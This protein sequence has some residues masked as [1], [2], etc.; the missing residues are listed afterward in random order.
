MPRIA[1][2]GAN[3]LPEDAHS[4]LEFA[5]ANDYQAVELYGGFPQAHFEDLDGAAREKL[6]SLA[7]KA[8]ITLSLHAPWIDLNV[9]SFNR[10]IREES[11]RQQKG[12]LDLAADLGAGVLVMHAGDV[13]GKVEIARE[14]CFNHALESVKEISGHA[15][16][17]DVLL[18]LENVIFEPW[19]VDSSYQDLLTIKEH[20][21]SPNLKFTL[22]FGHA[23]LGGGIREG[24]EA[25][26][27]DIKHI[28]LSDN[29]GRGDD[30][31]VIGRGTADYTP[32]TDFLKSFQ[33]LIVLEVMGLAEDSRSRALE[34]R[35]Y[36][37]RLLQT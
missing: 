1:L 28:H 34:S 9:A 16:G 11:V 29:G 13:S 14:I 31:Q 36:V 18:C 7:E 32:Y 8:D 6:R 19:A 3:L 15:V 24:I 33:G 10:G 25:L 27:L 26:G 2:A 5:A 12:A 21:G 37:L 4:A 20:A 22:D 17:K 30:H 23:R 35:E